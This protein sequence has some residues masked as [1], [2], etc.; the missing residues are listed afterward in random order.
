MKGNNVEREKE[1]LFNDENHG[2]NEKDVIAF[3]Q[4]TKMK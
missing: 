4:Q 3:I 2:M 1:Y